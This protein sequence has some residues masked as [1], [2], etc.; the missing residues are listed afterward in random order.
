MTPDF[1]GV[2]YHQ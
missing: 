2:T 1:L